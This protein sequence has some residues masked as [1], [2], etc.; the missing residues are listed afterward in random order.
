VQRSSLRAKGE[1]GDRWITQ[2]FGDQAASKVPGRTGVF[3]LID[4][5]TG[6]SARPT[7]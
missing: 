7:S 2:V 6:N 4:W 3:P 5:G 1:V